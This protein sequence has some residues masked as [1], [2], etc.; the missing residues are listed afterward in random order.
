MGIHVPDLSASAFDRIS[1]IAAKEAGLNLPPSKHAMVAARLGR[2][3]SR[4]GISDYDAY[5]DLITAP[6]SRERRRMVATLTTNV[7]KFFRERHHFD[8]L[9]AQI[10]PALLRSARNGQRVRIWSA[11]CANGQEAVSM[12]ICLLQQ[13]PHAHELDIRILGTDI[14]PSVIRYAQLGTYHTSMLGGLSDADVQGYF[15]PDRSANSVRVDHRVQQ[16]TLFRELNL[17]GHWPMPGQFN[18]I[19]C[20]NVVIYFDRAHQD[21]LWARYH[22]KLARQGYLFVGH[23]ERVPPGFGYTGLPG[24][25]TAYQKT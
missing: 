3:L 15:R 17:H 1:Q 4:L 6:H 10:F 14:D 9:S 13:D 16:M 5:L 24:C 25:H 18:V 20:R 2:R 19:F 22:A 8:L 12:A 7:S 21:R 23:S 11:G